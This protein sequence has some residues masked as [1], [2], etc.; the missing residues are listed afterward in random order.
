MDEDTEKN[1][2]DETGRIDI[3]IDFDEELGWKGDWLITITLEDA[4]DQEPGGI[5]IPNPLATDNSN[6][7]TLTVEIEWRND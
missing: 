3:T 1:S 4:G 6:D 5:G 7:Y 2:D